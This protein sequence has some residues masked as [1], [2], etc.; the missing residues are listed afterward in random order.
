[1]K[2]KDEMNLFFFGLKLLKER[3]RK[4]R[5]TTNTNQP[6]QSNEGDTTS[7][8]QQQEIQLFLKRNYLP[9]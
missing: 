6:L 4:K 7:V 1:M 3:K 8:C 9:L 2:R 5:K